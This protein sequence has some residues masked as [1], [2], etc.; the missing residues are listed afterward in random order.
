MRETFLI[1]FRLKTV[2]RVN[3]ILF[4]IRQLVSK[5]RIFPHDVFGIRWIKTLA[6]V[7]AGIREVLGIFLG[8]LTFIGLMFAVIIGPA[9]A[10]NITPDT[11][12]LTAY[13]F[14]TLAGA[15]LDPWMFSF[16]RHDYYALV[17]MRMNARDRALSGFIYAVGGSIVGLLPFL[18]VF[19]S[20]LGLPWWT[21]LIMALL[22]SAVKSLVTAGQMAYYR[23]TGGFNASKP[24]GALTWPLIIGLA[25]I[26]IGL[27]VLG[28]ALPRGVALVVMLVLIVGGVAAAPAI[29]R[30][31]YY[32]ELCKRGATQTVEVLDSVKKG[33]VQREQMDKAIRLDAADASSARGKTGLAYLNA[34]FIARHRKILW[35][36][37]LRYSALCAFVVVVAVVAYLVRPVPMPDP[38]GFMPAMLFAMYFVN[39]GAVMTQAMYANCDHSFLTY[40]FYKQPKPILELFVLR[41]VEIVKLN[42]LPAGI[43]GAGMV[44][45]MAIENAARPFYEY[46]LAFAAM[47]LIGVFFSV[48]YLALY[49]LLQPYTS[50]AVVK[51][52][53][54]QLTTGLTYLACYFLA[55]YYTNPSLLVFAGGSLVFCVLYS[56]VACM[57]VFRFA[58]RTFRLKA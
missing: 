48:H 44:A 3:M 5:L 37:T 16:Y 6:V 34:V 18:L 21:A 14:L 47:L 54:Y 58:P 45:L 43:L 42:L 46:P 22:P 1:S 57:A 29:L 20:R 49:Y 53:P 33:A 17:L 28:W 40:P 36:A 12:F 13:L 26:G 10:L 11:S 39:R 19:G 9:A 32:P 2:Y 50:E 51:S 41:L 30:F 8:N 25:V 24:I 35:G 31:A 15:C 23:R 7:L 55:V 52:Y 38:V 27:T 56:V 4:G